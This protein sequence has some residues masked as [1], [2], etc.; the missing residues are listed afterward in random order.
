MGV[1][2]KRA[3]YDTFDSFLKQPLEEQ[4]EMLETL[5]D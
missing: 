3:F 2:S 1:E 5:R 4:L